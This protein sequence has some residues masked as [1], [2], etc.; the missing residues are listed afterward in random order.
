MC[1][2][3]SKISCLR[4]AK[5]THHLMDSASTPTHAQYDRSHALAHIPK[6]IDNWRERERERE[7]ERGRARERAESLREE[8]V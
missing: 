8:R 6:P 3:K 1:L 2:W 4:E 5:K 7:R